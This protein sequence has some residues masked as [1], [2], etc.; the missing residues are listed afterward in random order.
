MLE[1]WLT[2]RAWTG[3]SRQDA[4]AEAARRRGQAGAA[5]CEGACVCVEVALLKHVRLLLYM[6]GRV[7]ISTCGWYTVYRCAEE[8]TDGR[9]I[10]FAKKISSFLQG[11]LSVCPSVSP[12][13]SGSLRE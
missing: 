13:L 12:Y 9:R 5:A 1:R 3:L 8:S 6:C 7:C 10:S 11:D 4:D 2:E